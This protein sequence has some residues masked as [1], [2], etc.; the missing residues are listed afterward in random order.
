MAYHDDLLAQAGELI[1]GRQPNSTQAGLRRA[2]STAYYALFHLLISE[3]SRNW[4]RESSRDA[5]GRLFDHTLMRKAPQR[6]LDRRLFL[7]DGEDPALVKN[8]RSVA[9]AFVQ[10]QHKRHIADYSVATQW[11]LTESL[12]EITTARQ[13][14]ESWGSI[15]NENIAQEYLVSL[16]IKPR[17]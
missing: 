2:V 5:F 6:I 9:Q 10:L 3:S 13:A 16:L 17:D 11:T 1:H 12:Y 15:R 8:L 14:F 7:F 4:S